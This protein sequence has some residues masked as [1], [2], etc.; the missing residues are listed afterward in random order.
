MRIT[1]DTNAVRELLQARPR[2]AV[3]QRVLILAEEGNGG[4][5]ITAKIEQDIPDGPLRE[6]IIR[7]PELAIVE[8]PAVGRW[9]EAMWDVSVWG[10]GE[11]VA[12]WDAAVAQFGAGHPGWAP[13]DARDEDHLHSHYVHGHDY[14]VTLDRALLSVGALLNTSLGLQVL[15]PEKMVA[16][17]SG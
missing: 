12:A 14:F 7:L 3:V 9:G 1:L 2:A 17:L 15:T 13:P 5:Y 4:V 16:L 11:F 10:D 8:V 6:M